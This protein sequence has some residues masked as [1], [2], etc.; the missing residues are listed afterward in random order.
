MSVSISCEYVA[1]DLNR[2][3]LLAS[4][5]IPVSGIDVSSSSRLHIDNISG[6][7]HYIKIMENLEM[8]S[9][10]F[11]SGK[12]HISGNLRKICLKPGHSK[13]IY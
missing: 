12:R 2:S 9:T 8:I 5:K 7:P 13:G 4:T 6:F 11:Q 3:F 1:A 10:F